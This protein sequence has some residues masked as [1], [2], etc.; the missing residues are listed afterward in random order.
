MELM[1]ENDHW[2]EINWLVWSTA[3]IAKENLTFRGESLQKIYKRSFE[4]LLFFVN[5]G[6]DGI[7]FGYKILARRAQDSNIYAWYPID[8]EA[9]QVAPSL[10]AFFEGWLTGKIRV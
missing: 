3:E 4:D 5:A 1:K 10:E 9:I 6:V 8:N 2:V 7:L